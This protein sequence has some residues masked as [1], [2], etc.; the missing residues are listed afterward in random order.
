MLPFDL[1]AT[2]TGNHTHMGNLHGSPAHVEHTWEK[3]I[4]DYF[5]K[6][7]VRVRGTQETVLENKDETNH[8][9]YETETI[10]EII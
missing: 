3:T 6:L 8:Y 9:D 4:V 2:E 10:P 7:V 1:A 5:Y